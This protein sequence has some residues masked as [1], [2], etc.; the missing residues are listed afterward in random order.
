MSNRMA[1]PQRPPFGF[2]GLMTLLL[3]ACLGV[4]AWRGGVFESLIGA[5]R[6]SSVLAGKGVHKAGSGVRPA[7][8]AVLPPLAP[9]ARDPQGDLEAVQR[10]VQMGYPLYCGGGKG[11]FV[12]LTFDDGPGPYTTK[13]LEILQKARARATFFLVGRNLGWYRGLAE[14]ETPDNAVGDHTWTHAYLTKLP[15]ADQEHEIDSTR[16]A[17]AAATAGQVVLFRPP[18]GFHNEGIDRL[19]SSF[20]MLETMWSVDSMDSAGATT[21]EVLDNVI[22]GLKPGAIILMH[23]NRGTTLQMLPRFLRTVAH[24]G[25]QTVTVPELLRLDP[26]SA[27]QMRKNASLRGCVA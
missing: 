26:P 2:R 7:K 20:G 6:T 22:A 9:A 11:K 16:Q 18:G 12:A 13:T 23:E 17:V 25:F 8:A 3:V 24:Q 27:D 19:V 4:V 14:Q 15:L 1:P 10:Y 5:R 21:R